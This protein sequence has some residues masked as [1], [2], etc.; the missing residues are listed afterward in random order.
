[1]GGKLF[2]GGVEVSKTS[3]EIATALNNLD[4]MLKLRHEIEECCTEAF[5]APADREKFKSGLS[6]LVET[7]NAFKQVLTAEA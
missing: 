6:E 2:L 5:S 7:S 4:V 3:T 1:M